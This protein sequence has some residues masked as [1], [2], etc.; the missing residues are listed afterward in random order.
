MRR[1]ATMLIVSLTS[2]MPH[3]YGNELNIVSGSS[4]S[5]NSITIIQTSPGDTNT[6]TKVE[7]GPGGI[8]VKQ[9]GQSNGESVIQRTGPQDTKK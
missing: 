6:E 9:Q 4:G 7:S 5:Q 8:L 1:F 2:M 3:A